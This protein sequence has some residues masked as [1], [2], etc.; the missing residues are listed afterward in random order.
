MF[1]YIL[2][3]IREFE[4]KYINKSSDLT[5]QNLRDLDVS[6]HETE[7]IITL[8]N[9]NVVNTEYLHNL[10][11]YDDENTEQTKTVIEPEINNYTT[12]MRRKLRHNINVSE[13]VL[14]HICNTH[15]KEC[16][17][18]LLP[19]DHAFHYECINNYLKSIQS[20]PICDVKLNNNIPTKEY[21]KEKYSYE[22]LIQYMIELGVIESEEYTYQ[23]EDIMI[24]K[25]IN[26]FIQIS[27]NKS[28]KRSSSNDSI[29]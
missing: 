24:E 13:K 7:N 20:C 28:L 15:F 23:D 6:Y 14:C 3:T 1:T 11:K 9:N 27:E 21:I 10:K 18:T 29:I 12:I 2:K 22:S 19:C 25:M 4:N 16:I 5:E 26:Y 17:C 8:K